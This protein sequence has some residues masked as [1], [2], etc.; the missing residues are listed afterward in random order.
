MKTL[1]RKMYWWVRSHISVIAFV[2]GFVWDTLTLKRIDL[3]YENIA[4]ITYLVIAFV[5]I[6]L[7]HG[8][9]TRR[10]SS[11][12]LLNT[13]VWLPALVQF[14]M[15]GLM[16][17]FMIFY[18][19]SASLLTSWPFLA[20][21]LTLLIGNEFFR[22]RYEKLVFQVSM[23][24]FA[25][26]SY[27]TLTM[28]ILLGTMGTSTFIFGGILS[29][30]VMGCLLAFLYVLFPKLF[31]KGGRQVWGTVAGVFM[32]F[33]VLYFTNIIPPV[34]LVLTE[35]G[36]YH[37]V[38]RSGMGEYTV[39]YE[40]PKWFEVWRSTHGTYHKVS[41]EA[42]YCFS[43]VFAPTRL[44]VPI[45]HSWQRKSGEGVWIRDARIPFT[46]EGGR[47]GGYRGYT[48]KQN[49]QEGEWR[50]VVETETKQVVGEVRFIVLE[51]G[52]PVTLKSGVR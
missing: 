6:V 48:I 49:L 21:L 51:G 4:F 19:K 50:C 33:N 34:P 7:L 30:L 2:S 23:F 22:K 28:P 12:F 9:E 32:I 27:I 42:G 45:Y 18:S 52:A 31:Q 13:R 16:S 11:R 40:E 37:S 36:I 44:R 41:G 38:V 17:G 25:L 20:I 24:Y 8:V 46:I 5:G 15:G 47:L 10:F 3:L 35:I 14:P 29:L 26:I 43:S 39:T 1:A